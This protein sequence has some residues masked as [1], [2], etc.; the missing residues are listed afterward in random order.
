V[1]FGRPVFSRASFNATIP[2]P[3]L[4]VSLTPPASWPERG[5]GSTSAGCEGEGA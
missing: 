2:L 5:V 4:P 1:F 3:F